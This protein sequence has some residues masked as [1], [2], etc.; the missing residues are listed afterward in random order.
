MIP[1]PSQVRIWL[2]VGRTDMRSGMQGL[3]LQ[4]QETLG[5]DPHA[6]DLYVFRGR[7]G[8]L[9]KI[10]WHDGLV[11]EIEEGNQVRLKCDSGSTVT[12]SNA[13]F[14]TNSPINTWVKIH[15][16]MAP[17]R[18][19]AMAFDISK[20]TLPDALYWDM[21]D[22]YY[23]VR[24]NPGTGK[25]DR[26]IVGG[27]DHRSGEADDGE[28]RFTALEAW[29]RALVPELSRERARWSGQVLETIDYCGFIVR[30]PG[31]GNV[32][33]ATGD[34]GQGMTHGALAGLLSMI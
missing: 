3:A 31:N 34:S 32:F 19:Y 33:V 25:T 20:G 5:R 22:P 6:G 28:A 7:S 4:V 16:K 13:V 15:S 11:I 14:A 9:I 1:V 12:A 30:S 27:R 21:D 8:N 23:Y 18:T 2:A 24:L 26:L 10:I 17:Y 29:I